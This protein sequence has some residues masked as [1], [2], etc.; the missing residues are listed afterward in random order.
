MRHSQSAHQKSTSQQ[1][2]RVH[3]R[4]ND[5]SDVK[6]FEQ[7]SNSTKT[8]TSKLGEFSNLDFP[9]FESPDKQK[10][11]TLLKP[12]PIDMSKLLAEVDTEVSSSSSSELL[13]TMDSGERMTVATRV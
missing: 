7:S 11:K 4:P 10:P 9:K 6:N 3:Q 1:K 12:D 8:K 2:P 13:G 5:F